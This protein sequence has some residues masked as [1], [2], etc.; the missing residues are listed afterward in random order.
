MGIIM[1]IESKRFLRQHGIE[2]IKIHASNLSEPGK[3]RVELSTLLEMYAGKEIPNNISL[4]TGR[5]Y[6]SR[7]GL[8]RD[9]IEKQ[10]SPIYYPFECNEGLSYTTNGLVARDDMHIE[11]PFDLIEEVKA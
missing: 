11:H 10:H 2:D 3:D 8:V 6:M 4:E 5:S 7:C 9:I 1:S